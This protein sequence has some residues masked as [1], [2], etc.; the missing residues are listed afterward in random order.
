[1]EGAHRVGVFRAGVQ[2]HDGAAIRNSA[3]AE[4]D[5]FGNRY[6]VHGPL[7]PMRALTTCFLLLLVRTFHLQI[8]AKFPSSTP[9]ALRARRWRGLSESRSYTSLR[10]PPRR[11]TVP[12]EKRGPET[13]L[14]TLPPLPESRPAK[15]HS[16]F[17]RTLSHITNV[18][19]SA[20]KRFRQR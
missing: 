8:P 10:R 4:T 20:N 12:A 5:Q 11:R 1:M 18:R 2:H 3:H 16:L 14:L 9:P 19:P 6:A 7:D 13:P 15:R 17:L